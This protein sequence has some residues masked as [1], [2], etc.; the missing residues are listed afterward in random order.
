MKEEFS[1][2]AQTLFQIDVEYSQTRMRLRKKEKKEG[3]GYKCM[4]VETE[5]ELD[6]LKGDVKREFTGIKSIF[7]HIKIVSITMQ[8][9]S[10]YSFKLII[11]VVKSTIKFMKLMPNYIS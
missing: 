4:D 1:S 2:F 11:I 5:G 6:R 9:P 7:M 10:L 8:M 3:R